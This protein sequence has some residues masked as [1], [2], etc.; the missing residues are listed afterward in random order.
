MTECETNAT[1]EL[2]KEP[3]LKCGGERAPGPVLCAECREAERREEAPRM[4]LMAV[5][6]GR[7]A[8]RHPRAL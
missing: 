7:V 2:D 4:G 5:V 8:Q 6:L 1:T 3:C